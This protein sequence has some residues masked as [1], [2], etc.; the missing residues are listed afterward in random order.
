MEVWV[1]SQ[2]SPYWMCCGHNVTRD[3]FF[4][5]YVKFLLVITVLLIIHI[6]SSV[7]LVWLTEPSEAAF[8]QMYCHTTMR[9]KKNVV[10]YIVSVS[11]HSVT[12]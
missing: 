1:Q 11:L 10:R 3:T 6:V 7:T 4:S 8:Q 2:G 9:I 5:D 12:W